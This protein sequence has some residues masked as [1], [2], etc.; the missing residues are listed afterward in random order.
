MGSVCTLHLKGSVLAGA[1]RN[2]KRSLHL[3]RSVLARDSRNGKCTIH[4]K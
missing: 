1:S 2:G 3:K 4:L